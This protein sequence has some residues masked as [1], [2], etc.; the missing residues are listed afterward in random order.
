MLD[1][2]HMFV[3]IKSNRELASVRACVPA[4]HQEGAENLRTV[5]VAVLEW[6]RVPERSAIAFRSLNEIAIAMKI[7]RTNVF[8]QKQVHF[9]RKVL[10][11][12]E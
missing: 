8:E 9:V 6:L 3:C 2:Y 4:S 12:I 10:R 1:Y 5:R 7:H 11:Q